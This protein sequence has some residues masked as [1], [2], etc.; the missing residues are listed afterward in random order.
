MVHPI[1]AHFDEHME[2][3][4]A[5]ALRAVANRL[6]L[7]FPERSAEDI[8]RAMLRAEQ[9][10]DGR[11][12]RTFVPVFVERAVADAFQETNV[13]GAVE[14]RIPRQRSSERGPTISA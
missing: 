14:V 8:N 1:R 4:E 13:T 7:R 3:D 2:P 10:F 9:E 11:P 6:R 5:A 12:I